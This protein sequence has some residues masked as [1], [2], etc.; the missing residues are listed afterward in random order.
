MDWFFG[1]LQVAIGAIALWVAWKALVISRD[2]Q[3]DAE[4]ERT[5]AANRDRL[6][7]MQTLLNQLGPLQNEGSAHEIEYMD[8]QRWM[9]TCLAV[10]GLRK[11]LPLTMGLTDRPF[12]D[13]SSDGWPGFVEAVA[14]ARKEIHEALE[15]EGDRAYAGERLG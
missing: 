10:G 5:R 3:R 6:M 8:L 15:L 13:G 12:S 11:R 1:T 9:K 4:R 7:W 14:A 2:L